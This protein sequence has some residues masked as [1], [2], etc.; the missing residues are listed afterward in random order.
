MSAKTEIVA[1]LHRILRT[2]QLVVDDTETT[3]KDV[4]S[5]EASN[6]DFAGCLIERVR[7]AHECEYT[8]TFDKHSASSGMRLIE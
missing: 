4:Y 7:T 8:S 3:W 2:R 1:V 6:A 5:F